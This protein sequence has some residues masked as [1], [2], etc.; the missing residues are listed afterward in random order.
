MAV[1]GHASGSRAMSTEQDRPRQNTAWPLAF[2]FQIIFQIYLLLISLG[3]AKTA[4]S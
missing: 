3:R 4:V 1:Y 2:F